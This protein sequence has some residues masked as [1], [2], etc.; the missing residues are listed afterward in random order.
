MTIRNK[1]D[2]RGPTSRHRN[3][4]GDIMTMTSIFVVFLMVAFWA[5]MS[6]SQQWN[7]RRD[8][9]GVAA[10]AARAA[11]QGDSVA[12][13]SGTIIDPAVAQSSAM[14]VL[15]AA[16]YRGTVKIDGLDVTV[17][18]TGTV[19]YAFPSPGF[20][21]EVTATAQARLVR[22]VTGTEGA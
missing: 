17:V 11:A 7:T 21:G 6:A 18:V 16:G 4:H 22:G 15:E 8:V 1:Q 20:D 5:L 12:I 14:A 10:A 19:A 13:R 2:G 9:Q 3:E